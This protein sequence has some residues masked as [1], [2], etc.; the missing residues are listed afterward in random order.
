MIEC[1]TVRQPWA[2]A[3]F[4]QPV[5][6]DVEN[7]SWSTGYRGTLAIHAGLQI[8]EHGV[9]AIGEPRGDDARDL[10]HIIG[11][12]ELV[13][14]H[15]AGGPGCDETAWRCH[16][17]PWAFWPTEHGQ[18]IVHWV[19]ER[20]RRLITPIRARGQVGLWSPGPSIEHLL[21]IAE[22]HT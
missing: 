20:P 1:L 13:D 9:A 12:V 7:R 11:L 19:V 8:D 10:G 14:C 15:E 21:T 3:F 18:R 22:V 6:K 4:S 17:N 16:G 5:G 2:G